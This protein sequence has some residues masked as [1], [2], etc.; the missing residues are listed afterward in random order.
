MGSGT[1]GAVL[2]GT[3]PSPGS[4]MGAA[5]AGRKGGNGSF[6]VGRERGT[7]GCRERGAR[8][9]DAAAT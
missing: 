4:P 8:L 2:K 6:E 5:P 3:A 1:A 9:S 7:G